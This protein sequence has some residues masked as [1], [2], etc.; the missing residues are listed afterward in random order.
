V[1]RKD[2]DPRLLALG[3]DV[4][5]GR[6]IDWETTRGNATDGE[7][8]TLIDNLR[9]I[10]NMVQAH[11]GVGDVAQRSTVGTNMTSWHHLLLIETVGV[12]ACGT[13][14]RAWDT[15][16]DRE[17]ALKLLRKSSDALR[18]ALGEGRHLA[19]IRH[20][21]V[22][23]VYGAED[24]EGQV[25]IWMEF[26][27]GDTLAAMIADRGPMSAREVVGIGIELC[28]ALS[29][30][31]HAGLVHRDIKANNVMREVGG[32]IVLMDFSGAL[33]MGTAEGPAQITG[34]PLYMAPEVLNGGAPSIA[35]DIYSLGVLLFNLL[36]ARYPIEGATVTDV[37]AAHSNAVR[38]R[39]RDLRPEVPEPLIQVIESATASDPGARHRTA[40]E[41]EHAL[42]LTFGAQGPTAAATSAPD[43]SSRPASLPHRRLAASFWLAFGAA[44][45][46]LGALSVIGWSRTAPLSD[47]V[48]V[49]TTLG[50][51]YNTLSW[52]RVSPDGRLVMFGTIVESK[53]V[54]W[55]R[56]LGSLDGTPLLNASAAET[57]F[58]SPD[59]KD[60]A[61]FEDR[62]LK[63]IP[64]AGGS[65]EILADA[66]YPHGGDW[67]RQGTLIFS[68][69][70]VLYRIAADGSSR[71]QLTRLDATR[72]EY[73]HSWPHFL[74][75]GRRYLFIVRSKEPEVS[76]LY[77]GALDSGLK[78]RLMPPYS[79]TVYTGTT[80]H[81]LFVHSGSLMAQGFDP[82]RA[83]LL[84][85]PTQI[86]G[87]VK[88]HPEGDAAF[89]VS[90]NGVLVYRP[91]EGQPKTRL[92]LFDRRGREL[93]VVGPTGFYRSPHFSPDQQRV[94]V[95]RFSPGSDNPDLWIYDLA[96]GGE[97]RFTSSEA[98]DVAARWS[99]DGRK[100]AFSSRRHTDFDIYVKGVDT[101]EAER[102]LDE[103]PG[104]KFVED[105]SPDSRW[106]SAT[107]VRNG[108]WIMPVGRGPKP[109]MIRR[110]TVLQSWQSE[111]SPDGRWVVYAS[112]ETTPPEVYAE[113]VPTTG[114]RWQ[115]STH[116]GAEP[117][118]RGDGREL[119]YL[120]PDGR[121][122]GVEVGSA[123]QWHTGPAHELF[124]VSVPELLG[125]TDVSLSRDG[126]LV[127]VNTLLSDPPVPPVH[128]LVNWPQVIR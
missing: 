14:H 108:L 21:N 88:F 25:G 54:L 113:P 127:L 119:V 53:D 77:V 82:R 51:P 121:L 28:R 55:V 79:R 12:G 104:D 124:R 63:K 78:T 97:S 117:H 52:P 91:A 67:S 37:R 60:I 3:V 115:V 116:G 103:S 50:S 111:F 125:P 93:R 40:G 107:I 44:I 114:E 70:D 2:D 23:T 41:L 8:G 29:A 5:D 68:S 74:P 18:D 62:K 27:Q 86:V 45:L 43:L 118:W 105:W 42:A 102:V 85:E 49:R 38:R 15:K 17:V 35:S 94:V 46:A 34:T 19:R 109:F 48:L 112:A 98:P 95:E 122:L 80:G 61:F 106:L 56:P 11:R 16:L 89:D 20:A 84:G 4:S 87:D 92:T 96:R 32:R 26:I 47:S 31:H 7:S 73:Q 110:S 100:I 39:L 101:T 24:C 99:P 1:T 30:L 75:D 10:S 57:G 90:R 83:V 72:G 128:V 71:Q 6:V 120:A 9:L 22:V 59:S 126:Q 65:P 64:A 123:S 81:L 66:P 76:G 13:V 33:V 36:T 58:W 69:N